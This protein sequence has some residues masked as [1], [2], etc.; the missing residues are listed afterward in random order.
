MRR[1]AGPHGAV[2]GMPANV[3]DCGNK[4]NPVD[5][6]AHY[7]AV[8]EEH[9]GSLKLLLYLTTLTCIYLARSKF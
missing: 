6:A 5:L 1:L 8:K 7:A 2:I 9:E 4:H 3:E